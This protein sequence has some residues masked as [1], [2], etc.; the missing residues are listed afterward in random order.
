MTVDWI[1]TYTGKKFYPQNPN[2]ADIDIMDVAHSL[3]NRC[4]FSGATYKFYCV[5]PETLIL[6]SGLDWIEARELGP[7]SIVCGHWSGSLP[8]RKSQRLPQPKSSTLTS[9]LTIPP[10]SRHLWRFRT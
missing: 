8:M 3:S 2:H 4:R 9:C 1:E 6:T 10:L 5:T 7:S